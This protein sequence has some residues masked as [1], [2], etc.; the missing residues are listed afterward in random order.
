MKSWI[1]FAG[2]VLKLYFS[3]LVGSQQELKIISNVLISTAFPSPLLSFYLNKSSRRVASRCMVCL[4]VFSDGCYS[5]CYLWQYKSMVAVGLVLIYC[6]S[7]KNTHPIQTQ[8]T[9]VSWSHLQHHRW[10]LKEG[11]RRE[12]KR[13]RSEHFFCGLGPSVWAFSEVGQFYFPN[14]HFLFKRYTLC[15]SYPWSSN[16]TFSHS[17]SNSE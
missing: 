14:T 16:L 11:W 4:K 3:P 8:L 17:V 15:S 1:M 13:R 10:W 9:R 7:M 5:C 6:H 12:E 2:S